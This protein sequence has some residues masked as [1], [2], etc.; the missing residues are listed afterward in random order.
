MPVSAGILLYRHD[1]NNKLE[2]LLG[3]PGGPFFSGKDAGAWS[4]LK[5][6]VED[7]EHLLGAAV[8]EFNEESGLS[9]V[10]SP[11]S[12]SLDSVK[13]GN[14]TIHVW[15]VETKKDLPQSWTPDSNT[16]KLEWPRGSG[17]IGVYPEINKVE[18]FSPDQARQKIN[19]NQTPFIDRLESNLSSL[20]EIKLYINTVK[21]RS[22]GTSMKLTINELKQIVL[23]EYKNILEE[24]RD[25]ETARARKGRTIKATYKGKKYQAKEGTLSMLGFKN[26]GGRW[27]GPAYPRT[28]EKKVKKAIKKLRDKEDIKNPGKLVNAAKI[29][30]A[31]KAGRPELLDISAKTESDIRKK[32]PGGRS[33]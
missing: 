11:D 5:G 3:H 23:E 9:I 14:K 24:K 12:I 27:T 2:I 4:A 21:K 32:R 17:N 22:K 7:G 26:V 8:R 10:L 18:F 16:F 13:Q 29:V 15:A 28:L 25:T 20:Q 6:G 31:M 19:K 33:K 30:G 1:K